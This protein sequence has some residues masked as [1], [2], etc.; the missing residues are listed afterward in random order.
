[1]LAPQIQTIVAVPVNTTGTYCGTVTLTASHF[2]NS[3]PF[4]FSASLTRDRAFGV[5]FTAIIDVPTTPI[6][7]KHVKIVL[8]AD[9]LILCCFILFL[10]SIGQKKKKKKQRGTRTRTSRLDLAFCQLNHLFL[11]RAP[12][13]FAKR[14]E[15]HYLKPL[16]P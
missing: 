11:I 3:E 16:I 15:P 6:V 10:L 1:M 8:V 7:A 5:A 14:K 13:N 9:L 2:D 4:S 12:V